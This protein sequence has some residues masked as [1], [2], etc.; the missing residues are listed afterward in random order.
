LLPFD[1]EVEDKKVQEEGLVLKEKGKEEELKDNFLE[2]H[3]M[4]NI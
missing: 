3:L 1:E 4:A 2:K